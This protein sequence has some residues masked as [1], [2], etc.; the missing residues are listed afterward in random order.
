MRFGT[1]NVTGLYR[2]GS[3]KT[4]ASGMAKYNFDLGAVQ[5]SDGLRAADSEQ[6][7]IRF[8]MEMETLTIS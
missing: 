1:W 8:S 3:L 7:I 5:E 6:T 4:V 2:A